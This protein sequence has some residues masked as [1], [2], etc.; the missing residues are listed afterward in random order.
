MEDALRELEEAYGSSDEDDEVSLL[1]WVAR[2]T[3]I[4]PI[5]SLHQDADED[6]DEDNYC[7]ACNRQMRSERAFAAHLKQKKHLE[8]VR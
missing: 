8:N 5:I 2:P 3:L 4:I 7:V 6:A 1:N